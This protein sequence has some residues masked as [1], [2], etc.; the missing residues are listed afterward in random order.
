MTADAMR[1]K[2]N[3]RYRD[4]DA[5]IPGPA[6][7]LMQYDYLLPESGHALELACG[8]G[9]N[10]I[11]LAE[12][13]FMVTAWDISDVAIRTL[14]NFSLSRNLMLDAEIRDVEQEPPEPASQDV[15][16]VSHFL[17]L[18]LMRHIVDAL[19]PGGLVYYQTWSI[20]R[21]PGMGGPSNPDF[22]LERNELLRAFSSL[23]V[24]AFHDE[25]LAGDLSRG[26]RGQSA[27]VARKA[28]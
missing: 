14:Q 9:G 5:T 26:L 2:W 6:W 20:D 28:V 7:V 23:D 15:I 13:G 4:S 19:R 21:M 16:V 11:H 22:L 1:R 8:L 17:H 10:A 3:A 25:G 27:I 12:K 18:P 24:L